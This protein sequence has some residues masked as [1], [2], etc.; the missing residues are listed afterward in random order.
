V[1]AA[2]ATELKY[3]FEEIYERFGGKILNLVFHMTGDK[4]AARDLTQEI[5]IKVYEN[6]DKFRGQSHIYTWIYRIALNHV[7]NY[8]KNQKRMRWKSFLNIDLIDVLKG[9]IPESNRTFAEESGAQAKLEKKEREKIVWKLILQLPVQQRVSLILHRYEGYSYQ[10]IADLL[11][12]SINA[13]ESRIY[14]AKQKLAKKLEKWQ[15]EI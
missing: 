13:V 14:R 1:E 5:F 6:L 8:L 12:I 3:S 11:N 4:E 9:R 7:T 2:V 15:N 10:E